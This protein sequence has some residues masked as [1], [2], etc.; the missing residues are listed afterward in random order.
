MK[1]SATY[2]LV[3]CLLAGA[4]RKDTT[5]PLPAEPEPLTTEIM[6]GRPEHP[7]KIHGYF[8]SHRYVVNYPTARVE[9]LD[10]VIFSNHAGD[11]GSAT[12]RNGEITQFNEN[13]VAGD[14]S[15]GEVALNG[16]SLTPISLTGPR[17]YYDAITRTVTL[18]SNMASWHYTGTG[19]IEAAKFDF[20]DPYPVYTTTNTNW[21]LEADSSLMIP[22]DAVFDN[23]NQGFMTLIYNS[24][25]G[26]GFISRTE[27]PDTKGYYYVPKLLVRN[28]FASGGGGSPSTMDMHAFNYYHKYHKG[29]L[30]LFV[31]GASI[32]FRAK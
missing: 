20:T 10:I 23:F 8:L 13:A 30:Y 7:D 5:Q 2:I 31:F 22:V 32:E 16:A 25:R 14:L 11:L 17:Y 6:P 1:R 27:F 26:S 21:P 9:S 28:L 3:I 19:E 15:V 29:K 18:N 12:F 24:Y 4:C